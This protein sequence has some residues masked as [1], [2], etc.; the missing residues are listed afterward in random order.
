MRRSF[1]FALS[2]LIV[3]LIAIMAWW[4]ARPEKSRKGKPD[5]LSSSQTV[6]VNLS[7]M[8][9]APRVTNT[10]LTPRQVR[11]NTVTNALPDPLD[12]VPDQAA[13]EKAVDD[14]L[15]SDNEEA[16]KSEQLLAMVPNLAEDAQVEVVQ[17]AANLA[18]DDHYGHITQVL[19]NPGTPEAVLS[20]LMTDLLNR[21]NE[22]KLPIVLTLARI[23][24]HPL[25]AEARE[26][27]EIYLQEDHGNDW[28]AWESSLQNW[29]KENG[30]EN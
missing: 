6:K 21:G 16:Q 26:L 24:R 11:P 7:A 22:L 13:W 10:V 14:I 2:I 17:H 19:I 9:F 29:L 12:S 3:L 20:V 4:T 27:L 25:Q 15:L 5:M 28:N 18:S 1:L 30:N 8:R 23:E